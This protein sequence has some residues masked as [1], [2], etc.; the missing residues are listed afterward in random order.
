MFRRRAPNTALNL[1]QLGPLLDQLFA[2]RFL[3]SLNARLIFLGEKFFDT[4]LRN[5]SFAAV[6]DA[7]IS[8]RPGQLDFMSRT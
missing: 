7:N 6:V 4:R 3:A 5:K 8:E 1:K 2:Q